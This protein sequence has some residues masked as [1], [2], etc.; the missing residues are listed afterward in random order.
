V[1][2]SLNGSVLKSPIIALG[3]TINPSC[4]ILSA[5]PSLWPRKT[6]QA[7][8]H[9]SEEGKKSFR[10]DA[11]NVYADDKEGEK[12]KNFFSSFRWAADDSLG[13]G[14]VDLSHLPSLQDRIAD[15]PRHRR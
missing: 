9:G 11:N 10:C 4:G 7:G 1:G 5:K 2:I 15:L 14:C 6:H 12:M 8:T 3:T 13:L